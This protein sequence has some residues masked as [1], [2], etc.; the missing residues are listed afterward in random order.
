MELATL[1]ETKKILLDQLTEALNAQHRSQNSIEIIQRAFLFAFEKHKEQSRKSGEPYIIHP[2]AVAITLINLW[3]DTATINAGLL[4]DTLED[5][6]TSKEEIAKEFGEITAELVDGVT[7]LGKLN[8]KSSQEQQAN[9]FRKML[10]AIAKDMRVVLVK[11][12]DRLNNMQ[13]LEHLAVEKR[14]RIAQETLD[15]FAPLANR[16]GLGS[17]KAELEDLAF[18]HKDSDEYKKIAEIVKSKKEERENDLSEIKDTIKNILEKNNIVAEIQGRAKHFYSIHRKLSKYRK[19]NPYRDDPPVYD[20]IGIRL[21][22]NSVKECYAALG[23]VHDSFRPMA[24]RFKDYIAMPKSNMYQSLHTT[25]VGPAGKPIEIQIR[26][27]EMHEIAE[28][29]IAAHWHYKES[30]GSNTAKDEDLEQLTWIRQLIS[31]DSDL[32]DAEEYLDTVKKDIFSQEV[33]TLSPQGDVYSLP[34]G[35]SPI[36]FAYK[37]HTKVGD[38]CSGAIVNERIVSLDYKLRN[39]DLVEIITNKNAHPNL[40]WLN[41]VKTNQAKHKIKSWYKKQN[42]DRHI[43]SG[44]ELVESSFGKTGIEQFLKSAEFLEV[45]NKLNYKTTEDLLAALG[46]GDNTIAQIK[47]RLKSTQYGETKAEDDLTKTVNKLKPRRAQVKGSDAEIPE[48][49]GL[50]YN[51]SKCCSP[52]PGEPVIGAISRGK[53]ISIHRTSC[54]NL[55]QMEQERLMEINWKEKEHRS[56]PAHINIEVIDRVGIVKDIL[57][58][59]ADENINIQDFKV[60]ERTSNTTAMLKLTVTVSGLD[61]LHKLCKMI[62]NMSDV[63][64]VERL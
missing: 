27:R 9:N 28:N 62:N 61:Q 36:D 47:G 29:G 30:K 16:F 59:I 57:T 8:F 42:R 51:I 4:H 13:T 19:D 24:G 17:I 38:T 12:A 53:G 63:L 23:L 34:V 18:K 15:I 22:V 50:L 54:H 40:T 11:L 10:M 25:V 60:K 6:A 7:K 39:G 56:F 14:Q 43:Q 37:V 33:Y 52:I 45:A 55:K 26:T 49:D 20:L 64:R 35:S 58:L 1:T 44:T 31:W 46:S 5:T 41:F 32:N 48:L 3:S 2:V 21:I